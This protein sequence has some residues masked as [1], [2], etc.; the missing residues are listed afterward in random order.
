MTYADWKSGVE[1]KVA[2]TLNIHHSVMALPLDFFVMFSSHV[3]LHGWYGQ[4]SYA[5]GNSYQDDFVQFRHSQGLAASVLDLGPIEDI[6]MLFENPELAR[7]M[8]ST[9]PRFLSEIELFEALELAIVRSRPGTMD[10]QI[11]SRLRPSIASM[12]ANS[13]LPWANDA[14]FLVYRNLEEDTC[15]NTTPSPLSN[16]LSDFLTSCSRDPSILT[17]ETAFTTLS[18]ELLLRICSFLAVGE[19]EQEALL[20]ANFSEL[21]LLNLG[22]DSMV[23]IEIRAWWRQRLGVEVSVLQILDCG[24]V[25]GLG[26]LAVHS[27]KERFD[28]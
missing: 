15:G 10:S 7:R 28:I 26:V 23:A 27:L 22:V 19:E 17:T 14:R 25:K 2:G 18:R 9:W 16:L 8:R 21:T 6:G 12:D 3:G 5:A 20:K 1:A 4:A 13:N 11:I 24:N